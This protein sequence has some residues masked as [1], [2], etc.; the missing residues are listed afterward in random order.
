MNNLGIVIGR[1]YMTRVKKK[2]F[3]ILTILMPFLIVAL[4]AFPIILG[5]IKD[6]EQKQVVIMDKTE[7]YLPLFVNASASGDSVSDNEMQG[8]KFVPGA[9]DL[10]LY[11][12][13]EMD[14]E[15][16]VCITEDL[17]SNPNA[18]KIYSRKEVQGDL[19]RH[20]ERVL[21]TQI[22]KDKLAAYNIPQLETIVSDLQTG[23]NIKT[24]KWGENGEETFSSSE[25]AMALGLISAILIYM[26]VLMYGAMVMQGVME[27]KTNRIVEVIV[28]S[29]KPFQLMMG[30]IIGVMLVGFTQMI[31]WAAMIIG[32]SAV[33]GISAM[34]SMT[35]PSVG[36]EG[37]QVAPQAALQAMESNPSAEIIQAISNLPLAEIGIMFL[38]FFLG[39][40]I[41]YSS[42]YAAIGAAVNSQE[43]SSQFMTPM[44]IVM[45]F[46]LYAAM[47]SAE[48]TDGPLAF[49][50]SMFPLTSPIVM[51]VR[52]PFGV[53]LWQEILSLV[54]LYTTAIL[55]VWVGGKIYRI[56]ILMYG[57]KPTVKEMW[58]WMKYS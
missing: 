10:Q 25:L 43:D 9:G 23:I 6:D 22:H 31:V 51:M 46:A 34:P 29:V 5:S 20:V 1:E 8:Y 21:D 14:I 54:I 41:L 17:T 52:I 57:K 50:A 39:G 38:F 49:W 42:F 7:K 13:E 48:N 12:S 33:I 27:E 16:V 45:V 53:P 40:Y 2:S 24:V 37:Q 47:G 30:K 18:V 19:I 36:M 28:G 55:F 3:L 11:N 58:K 32:I 56:G 26:F 44:V 15:A 35:G 4:G